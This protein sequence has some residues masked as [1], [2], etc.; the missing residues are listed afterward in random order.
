M[1]NEQKLYLLRSW[2]TENQIEYW[3]SVTIGDSGFIIPLYIPYTRIAIRIGDNQEW[4]MKVRSFVAPVIVRDT[5]SIEFVIEKVQNTI[6]HQTTVVKVSRK[7]YSYAREHRHAYIMRRR[8]K[9]HKSLIP[10]VR[11]CVA[12]TKTFKHGKILLNKT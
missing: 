8:R 11:H 4:Y 10:A 6:K 9:F 7:S 1:T 12:N 5:D 3:E 2:L